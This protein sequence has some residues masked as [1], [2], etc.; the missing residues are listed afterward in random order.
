MPSKTQT[1]NRC[2]PGPNPTEGANRIH[3]VTPS[4]PS[5][6]KNS[7]GPACE[8]FERR[9]TRRESVEPP[10][11]TLEVLPPGRFTDDSRGGP[12]IPPG[13]GPAIQRGEPS[14]LVDEKRDLVLLRAVSV[15]L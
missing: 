5:G 15:I 13:R 4:S 7:K 8:S 14:D 6:R 9:A 3:H 1:T 2:V 12:L 10:P 11:F